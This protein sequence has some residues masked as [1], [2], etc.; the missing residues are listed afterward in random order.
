[1]S[2]DWLN[3]SPAASLV[4]GLLIGVA[5]TFL[6]LG[7]GRFA[8]ISGIVSGLLDPGSRDFGWKSAFVAG[9][10]IAPSVLKPFSLV[11]WPDLQ[12]AGGTSGSLLDFVL[13]G[14]LA[15]IGARLA[16][17]CTSGH[18]ICGLG[19]FSRRSL[20]AVVLFMGAA[21]SVT[22]VFRHLA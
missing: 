22:Y 2:I 13:G 14:F 4:G 10:V 17:G 16:K 18:G 5:C 19:R 1:M 9:L 12:Q 15:G 8:G 11:E 21:M 6:L 3:F 20:V 7:I